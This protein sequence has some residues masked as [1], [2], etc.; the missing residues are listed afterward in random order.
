MYLTAPLFW[1]SLFPLLPFSMFYNPIPPS[2]FLLTNSSMFYLLFNLVSLPFL[3]TTDLFLI[4][5]CSLLSVW[6]RRWKTSINIHSLA[7]FI[8][9]KHHVA[10]PPLLSLP[11]SFILLLFSQCILL[12]GQGSSLTVPFTILK[13][14]VK[15]R[16]DHEMLQ[17]GWG[18]NKDLY[19]DWRKKSTWYNLIW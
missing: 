10:Q 15:P 2:S 7:V 19:T 17:C 14:I 12:T 18:E 9:I 3:S 8:P 5:L 6:V 13:S 11:H 16:F 1:K 4:I